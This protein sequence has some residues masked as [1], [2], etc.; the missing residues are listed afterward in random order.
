M[1]I[2]SCDRVHKLAVDGELHQFA[3]LGRCHR[4][5]FFTDHMLAGEQ[6][7]LDVRI[8]QVIWRGNVNDIDRGICKHRVQRSE[9]A[10]DAELRRL[11]LRLFFC[12]FSQP[13]TWMPLRRKPSICAGPMKPVP[14]T[15]TPMDCFV[16]Q[17]WP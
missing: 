9:A 7:G 12:L 4:Q 1:R 11:L 16:K 10:R 8:M 3:G 5:G 15:P 6:R 2:L 17:S 13:S 14:A